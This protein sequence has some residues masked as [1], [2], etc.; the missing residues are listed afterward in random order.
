MRVTHTTPKHHNRKLLTFSPDYYARV[1]GREII[2]NLS[3][4]AGLATMI[5]TMRP[6]IDNPDECVRASAARAGLRRR[7][8]CGRSRSAL[9]VIV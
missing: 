1:E 8:E 9:F 6:D 7:F 5:S 2:A 3:K 4:A